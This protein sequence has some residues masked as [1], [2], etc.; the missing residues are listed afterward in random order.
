MLVHDPPEQRLLYLRSDTPDVEVVDGDGVG[1]LRTELS[2][3]VDVDGR[4]HA[5]TLGRGDYTLLAR[6]PSGD[7]N[8]QPAAPA[9]G[10]SNE[11]TTA[12]VSRAGTT[13]MATGEEVYTWNGGGFT[14][15]AT[16][17]DPVEA[18]AVDRQGVVHA[19]V[20]TGSDQ[21]IYTRY[22]AATWGG[23][24]VIYDGRF[25]RT[26]LAIDDD[27]IG[28]AVV[29]V[30][31]NKGRELL[32][33]TTATGSWTVDP[34]AQGGED[35][36]SS[37]TVDAATRPHVSYHDGSAGVY[38]GWFDGSGWVRSRVGDATDVQETVV[39]V[40]PGTQ[41]PIVVYY[42]IATDTLRIYRGG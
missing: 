31:T 41:E 10:P 9:G 33:A 2:M 28:H 17:G 36:A 12:G 38:H 40:D 19:L 22:S 23:R 42:D 8:D 35:Q 37:L 1:S 24:T 7:W 26:R 21:V 16:P 27:D 11:P 34:L 20:G 4:V 13:W 5:A 39:L 15:R 30:S 3:A 29:E 6:E 32:Y 25:E 18:L 14:E